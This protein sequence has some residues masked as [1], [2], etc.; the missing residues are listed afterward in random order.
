[1]L[2]MFKLCRVFCVVAISFLTQLVS[3]QGMA[4]DYQAA[5]ALY[6][7]GDFL[8]ASLEAEKSHDLQGYTLALRAALAYGG[9][10]A[11]GQEAIEWLERADGL[12]NKINAI[13]NHGLRNQL[14]I[15]LV[16]SYQGKK[17][18]SVGLVKRA[19]G[20]IEGLIKDYPN[21]AMAY[22]ALAGWN[23]EIS[24]AGFLPKL[25]FGASRRKAR[26][27]FEKARSL[28]GTL[29][30]LNLEYAKYLARGS[31]EERLRAH[32]QLISIINAAPKDAF[33]RLLQENA[34]K[35]LKA[36]KTDKKKKIKH[37]I[38]EISAFPDF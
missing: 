9:H 38:A 6:E 20:M 3:Y 19:K 21:E 8:H 37:V 18:R 13:D 28:D 29:I 2:Q 30:P 14:S 1:M 36:V 17:L 5:Q 34:T 11:R 16:V 33:E 35:L 24:A 15:M 27:Y 22:A 25:V 4:Q 26:E 12:A 23:S 10:V 32:K 7:Q 31:K